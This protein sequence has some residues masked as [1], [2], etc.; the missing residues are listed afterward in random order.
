M[1][2]VLKEA[3]AVPASDN[4]AQL[5]DRLRGRARACLWA[6]RLCLIALVVAFAVGVAL[7]LWANKIVDFEVQL[8]PPVNLS[9]TGG[10]GASPVTVHI[11]QTV[12]KDVATEVLGL[13][14][15]I[16]VLNQVSALFA[17]IGV[18]CILVFLMQFMMRLFRYYHLT[19]LFFL[20]RAEALAL[21]KP[22]HIGL[23]KALT[24][25]SAEGV[26][27]GGLPKSPLEA[28]GAGARAGIDATKRTTG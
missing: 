3:P 12:N 16:R 23:D 21:S 24:L 5:I 8:H 14:W 7:F 4:M 27:F 25:L 10:T 22:E 11:D 2:P 19:H 1:S 15:K 20:A 6:S 26:E 9:L 18:I 28:I 17:R 13:D